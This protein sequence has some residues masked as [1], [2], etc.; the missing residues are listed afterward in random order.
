MDIISL[1]DF[2]VSNFQGKTAFTFRTPSKVM[3]DYVREIKISN[4]VGQH[5]TGKRKKKK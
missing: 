4:K 2:A 3:T 1:G 5:G